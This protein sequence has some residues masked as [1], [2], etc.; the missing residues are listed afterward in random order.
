MMPKWITP[1]YLLDP[2]GPPSVSDR[3]DSGPERAKYFQ[4]ESANR[5]AEFGTES[6]TKPPPSSIDD[7]IS[8]MLGKNTEPSSRYQAF[9]HARP[10]PYVT[11]LSPVD[12]SSF[13]QWVKTNKVPFDPGEKNSDY[14]MRGF[15]KALQSKDP[16]AVQ[17][18][19][20]NDKRM[21]FPDIWKTP[22]HKTFSAESKYAL[23]TAPKWVGNKLVEQQTGKVLFDDTAPKKS[24][25]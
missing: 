2:E 8:E 25:Q 18:L 23:P 12:E 7:L 6:P 24:E 16:L 15:W 4:E 9:D 3:P 11:P 17:A 10:G 1:Q 21:H 22:Y 14:D 5:N 20:P 13:R 19:D